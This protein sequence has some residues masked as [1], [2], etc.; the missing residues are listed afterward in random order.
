MH[1]KMI[2]C[3]TS[4][5][6]RANARHRRVSSPTP[7]ITS[8]IAAATAS[9]GTHGAATGTRSVSGW[10]NQGNSSWKKCGVSFWMPPQK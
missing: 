10:M 2:A 9:A 5:S 8:P 4:A 7:I 3:I 6:P 1:T